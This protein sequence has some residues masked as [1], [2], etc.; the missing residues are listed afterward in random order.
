MLRVSTIMQYGLMCCRKVIRILFLNMGK[1]RNILLPACRPGT[2]QKGCE[3]EANNVL[4]V[5]LE[6]RVRIF[7]PFKSQT[8]VV[9]MGTE[10]AP[11]IICAQLSL[12][13]VTVSR[14]RLKK[15]SARGN[16]VRF[17]FAACT[18]ELKY[19]KRD[20]QNATTLW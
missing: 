3:R 11:F 14:G 20:P 13:A 2:Q 12:V 7:F 5:L 17:R 18:I 8:D 9:E 6:L 19:H 15:K 16:T 10:I 4:H 1:E